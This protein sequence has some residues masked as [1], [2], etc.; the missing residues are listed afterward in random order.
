MKVLVSDNLEDVGLDILR[1]ESG[2]RS[3]YEPG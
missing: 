2:S 3:R 1:K